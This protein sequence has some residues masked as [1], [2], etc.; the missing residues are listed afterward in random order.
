MVVSDVNGNMQ[1]MPR[2]DNTK[3]VNLEGS[4]P[5]NT[6]M[7][8][9]ENHAKASVDDNASMGPQT[10]FF[11]R[12]QK[13][14]YRI[15]DNEG[16][17]ALRYQ[18]AGDYYPEIT[19]HFKSPLATDFKYYK[20]A[21]TYDSGTKT[22]TVS[23]EITGSLA[24]AELNSD[25]PTVYVRYSYNENYDKDNDKILQGKWFTIDLAAKNVQSTETT[26]NSTGDNV[27]LYSG[28]K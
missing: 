21:P 20:T 19:E 5:W 6:T 28:T 13:I 3:R 2:F 17:E 11:V 18:R 7:A 10:V 14:D 15:I 16:N 27:F 22:L 9:P 23:D 24:G 4:S 1:L 8:E 26:I 12:P 25:N